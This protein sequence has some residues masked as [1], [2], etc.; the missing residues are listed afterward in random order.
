M[1]GAIPPLPNTPSLR[2]VQLRKGTGQPYPFIIL[3]VC[4]A[5]IEL[6]GP[7]TAV[8]TGLYSQLRRP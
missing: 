3:N 6:R 5:H 1:R 2:G 4:T 7:V 8:C